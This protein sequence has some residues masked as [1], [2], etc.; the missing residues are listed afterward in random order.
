MPNRLKQLLA[1]GKVVRVF[2]MGQLCSPKLVEI[3]GMSN[4]FHAVW[5]DQEHAGLTIEQIENASRAARG[6]GLESFVRLTATDYAT[7]MRPLE[8]GAGG[9]MAAQVR[10]VHEVK[11]IIEWTK[12][13]PLGLR[14]VNGGGVDGGY[15]SI[16]LREYF[17]TANENSFVAIQIEHAQAVEVVDQIASVKEVDVLFVGPADLTQS[18]GIPGDMNHPRLWEALEQVARAAKAHGIHWAILPRDVPFAQRCLEM[19]CRMFSLGVDV[20]IAH[21]GIRTYLDEFADFF[22]MH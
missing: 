4:G 15:G 11:Q 18:L 10:S 17:R 6:V 19:G 12:F 20:W 14:G 22:Q 13:F 3:V 16:P 1:Q 8:A 21:R 5:F 7:V 2:G 9:I